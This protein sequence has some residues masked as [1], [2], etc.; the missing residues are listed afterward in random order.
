MGYYPPPPGA[1]AQPPPPEEEPLDCMS[2]PPGGLRLGLVFLA[3]LPKSAEEQNLMHL[4]W[5]RRVGLP[6][7][8]GVFRLQACCLSWLRRG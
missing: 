3:V 1:E 2:F 4:G 6:A 7:L 8:S 5:T